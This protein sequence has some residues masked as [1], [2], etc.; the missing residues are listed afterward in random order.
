MLFL[1]SSFGFKI[2]EWP[3]IF[4]PI[5]ICCLLLYLTFLIFFS[6]ILLARLIKPNHD[7]FEYK[8][9]RSYVKAIV[10]CFLSCGLTFESIYHIVYSNYNNY[11]SF[12]VLWAAFV[13][14][15]IM[16]IV[17]ILP[18]QKRLHELKS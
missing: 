11:N 7:L 1:L 14:C 3:D 6:I 2:N 16:V 18:F 17:N 12:L 9:R 13:Y 15:T 8:L 10:W 4:I 5:G